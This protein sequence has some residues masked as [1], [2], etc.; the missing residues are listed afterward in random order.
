MVAAERLSTDGWVLNER[1]SELVFSLSAVRVEGHTSLYEQPDLRERIRKTR[2]E[3]DLP[4]R[5]FYLQY[6]SRAPG[7]LPPCDGPTL[8]S[9]AVPTKSK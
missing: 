8:E 4:W 6:R 1:T 2:P 3:G 7:T 9:P 5:F